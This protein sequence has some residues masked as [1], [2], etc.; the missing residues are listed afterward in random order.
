MQRI[1]T[2]FSCAYLFFTGRQHYRLFTIHQISTLKI[3]DF[4]KVKPAERDRAQ[5]LAQ[6]AA[7]A[8]LYSD[9]QAEA[10]QR[11]AA[12]GT[13]ATAKTFEPGDVDDTTGGRS[14]VTANF[15]TEQKEQIRLLLINATSAKEVE[16]IESS[17]RRGVLPA[18]LQQ[19]QEQQPGNGKQSFSA[20]AANFTSEQTDQIRQLVIKAASSAEVEEIRESVKRGDLPPAL[21]DTEENSRK[22]PVEEPVPTLASESNGA[23]LL[24]TAVDGNSSEPPSKRAKADSG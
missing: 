1:L 14:F 5:R 19:A 21:Q 24:T 4:A 15:T 3:L 11:R 8:A 12:N 9:V 10:R 2:Q 13:G 23:D 22:R 7:G 17:V 18:A 6:S 20:T 16:E